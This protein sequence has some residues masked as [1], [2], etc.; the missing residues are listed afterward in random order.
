MV[1]TICQKT[2]ETS[3]TQSLLLHTYNF[4]AVVQEGA[5]HELL[6]EKMFEIPVV[7]TSV[8]LINKLWH[9]IARG[10]QAA[11]LL[12]DC[13]KAYVFIKDWIENW[14]KHLNFEQCKWIFSYV[15]TKTTKEN[16]L[17]LVYS[18]YLKLDK[19][20]LFFSLLVHIHWIHL[21]QKLAVMFVCVFLSYNVQIKEIHFI[22]SLI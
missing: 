4:W 10:L 17:K 3:F 8:S 20:D 15:W 18:I 1:F 6:H 11:K 16:N 2:F 21:N 19:S 14:G 5:Y 12:H 22:Q 9:S 7:E 13:L